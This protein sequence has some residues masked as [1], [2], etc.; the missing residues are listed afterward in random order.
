MML[1]TRQIK[2]T[3]LGLFTL[4]I[5][6]W[7]GAGTLSETAGKT[8]SGSTEP[9]PSS[10]PAA[11]D[12]YVGSDTCAACH[13]AQFKSF[14][15]TKHGE[16]HNLASWKGKVVG[17]ESCHGPGKAHV[18][19]EGDPTKIIS[20]K[21]MN[22][23]AVA[24]TCLTCHAGKETHNN[25]RRGEHWRNNVGCTDCHSPHGADHG[26]FKAGSQTFVAAATHQ[27]PGRATVA[28]LKQGEPQLCM[29][30]HNETKSQFSKP[31]HHKVLEGT[32][33][34]SDCHNPHG[35]YEQKQARLAVGA[36]AACVKC[37][38]NKQG[39]FVY[40][41]GPLKLEGC[42]ACHTPHGA[43]NSKML[44]RPQVRQ[45]CLECHSSITNPSDDLA[46]NAPSFHNQATVRYLECT[47]CHA[48]I[49]GSNT[50]KDFFR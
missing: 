39:P 32:M 20:F 21:K 31:F 26:D 38:A 43:S 2:L 25:F 1:S 45:L 18:E 37:H 42:S 8:N 22:A 5:L 9:V 24:E 23:K 16:L 4:L 47:V 13:E 27:N 34:C 6:V 46:P 48:A 29:S 44:K 11:D 30:C 35:G 14:D 36:D 41:H 28:M 49:H 17:C 40:E 15:A 50:N 19:G 7:F 10:T 33:T 12:N 3:F